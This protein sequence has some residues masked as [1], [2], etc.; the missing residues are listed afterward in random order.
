MAFL[1]ADEV[2]AHPAY[3]HL[4]WNLPAA[5]TGTTPVAQNRRG[6]PLN[7]YWQIHGHGPIKLVVRSPAQESKASNLTKKVHHGPQ[8]RAQRLEAPDQVLCP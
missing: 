4:D 6:G 2:I 3:K 7:L 5:S 1:T 8:R